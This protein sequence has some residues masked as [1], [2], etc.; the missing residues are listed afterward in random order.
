MVDAENKLGVNYNLVENMELNNFRIKTVI[1][2]KERYVILWEQATFE[3]NRKICL[4]MNDR[5]KWAITLSNQ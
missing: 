3:R 1:N 4:Y 5:N 2:T